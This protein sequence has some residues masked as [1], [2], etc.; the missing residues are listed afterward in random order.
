MTDSSSK[1]DPRRAVE[2]LPTGLEGLAALASDLRWTWSHACDDL[3]RAVDPAVWE[4]TRNPWLMLQETPAY[5]WDALARDP[6]F[7]AALAAIDDERRRYLETPGWGSSTGSATSL[8]PVAY[9]SMEYGFGAA[10]P[11]YAGGLGVLAADHLKT[12]SDLDVPVVGVGLL[13]QEGYFRQLIDAAGHQEALYPYNDP[14]ALPIRPERAASGDW[15]RVSVRLPGR[16]V[17]LRVWRATVGRV[18]LYL[19]DSNDPFN[20]PA[21]RGI[22][23]QLYGGGNE[24]RLRQELVLGIGGLRALDAVGI[25]PG[26]CHLNEGHTAFAVLERARG[27]MARTSLP[28][29]A[30]LWAT[31]AGNVFTTHTAVEAGFDAF[32][33]ALVAKY[34]PEGGE[35]LGALGL[36]LFELLALGRVNAEDDREPFRPATLA[37]RGAGHVNG[38]SALHGEV[39]RRLFQPLFPRFP[40]WE[41]PIAHVTNGVHTPTWDSRWADALWTEACGK[42]RWLRPTDAL[43]GAIA[44]ISD[45]ALWSARARAR[46]DLVCYARARIERQLAQRG[47]AP[48]AIASA[49]T[50]L[51]ADVLTL[52]FARRFAAYKRPNLLLRQSER[53]RALLTHGHRPVQLVIAGKAHP[54]DDEGKRLIEEWV[55]F[56]R[57]G[58]VRS[59]VVFL[60]DYDLPLAQEM[61]QGVDVW[62]NTPRRPLEACGTSGMK[63][64]VNG[65]LNLSV[66]DGW[67]AEAYAPDV[68]W[69]IGG[70]A[71][72]SGAAADERDT[73]DLYRVLEEKIIPLFYDR[74]QAGIPR[75]WL[76]L[77]RAS[78]SRLAPQFSSNRMVREYVEQLYRPA[79]AELERRLGDGGREALALAAWERS[80]RARLPG[81]H[82]GRLSVAADGKEWKVS[83]ELYLDGLDP[84]DASVELYADASG[85]RPAVRAPMTALQPLAGT[86]SGHL[87]ECRVAA[88][89]PADNFTP[90]LIPTHGELRA[91]RE[92]PLVSWHH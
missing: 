42:D 64:L 22:T 8:R 78:L 13:Y 69:V 25:A 46:H 4:V 75:R 3:W 31:R 84:A 11:L 30:A 47:A 2:S 33:P 20:A 6:T 41:V 50:L 5:R 81:V 23:N 37:L 73:E 26:V 74:D 45:E 17:Q 49:E 85:P 62:I 79:E 72:G 89:R 38:V 86:S 92:L 70:A 29:P 53:L 59:R 90:R 56:I 12:A 87:Y 58:A 54:D 14:T 44:A 71:D 43:E 28:F 57:S 48:A 68:G 80:V 24:M 91:P 21:D 40:S 1:R 76:E 16:D 77:V 88:D 34:F 10:L 61:V 9:L 36:S 65:G 82:W 51:D 52:G 67:W 15:L 35:L 55:S 83:V 60:E 7:L 66:A 63:V 18:A 39:S 27:V 32:E 19:L